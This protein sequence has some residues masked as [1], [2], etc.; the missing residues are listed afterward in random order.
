M[1]NI[2]I[3]YRREDTG[4]YAGRLYDRLAARFGR[5]HVFM[6]VD[7][8]EPGEDFVQAIEEKVAQCDA[9]VAVIGKNW[10][11]CTDEMGHRRLDDPHDFVRLE[12]SSALERKI[13]V[14]PAL[15][16]D[17]Q[18]PRP[19]DLPE[20]LI[21]LARRNAL[22]VS[23]TLFSQSVELLIATLERATATVPKKTSIPAGLATSASEPTGRREEVHISAAAA[24]QGKAPRGKWT[25]ILGVA[26][27]W[28]LAEWSRSLLFLAPWFWYWD[29][30]HG[31]YLISLFGGIFLLLFFLVPPAIKRLRAKG[32]A[33]TLGSLREIVF[34]AREIVFSACGV[35][36]GLILETWI[37]ALHVD[38]PLI[39]LS[40]PSE[41]LSYAI[42][43]LVSAMF[44]VFPLF[45]NKPL[46][47]AKVLSANAASWAAASLLGNVFHLYH[48]DFSPD[49]LH[50]YRHLLD[51]LFIGT[52]SGWSVFWV[53]S[54]RD[55]DGVAN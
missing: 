2:F 53:L 50:S 20:Q 16:D 36:I 55:R 25:L 46:L 27:C 19:Q 37:Y 5:D 4:G 47:V 33:Y 41:C 44:L 52:V 17:A 14:V 11:A 23:N 18:M 38:Y 49:L 8:L 21:L 30:L 10:L 48:H 43:G 22:N 54:R 15:V 39:R 29:D 9:L 6:D 34:S 51:G 32:L 7:T 1:A 40:I 45:R 3:S 12:I 26:V 42:G 24:S 31:Q 35:S 28:I 13:R